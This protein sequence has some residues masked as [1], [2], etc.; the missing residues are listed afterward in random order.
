MAEGVEAAGALRRRRLAVALEHGRG[1]HG[2][3]ALE[4]RDAAAADEVVAVDGAAAGAHLGREARPVA[5]QVLDDAGAS[6]AEHRLTGAQAGDVREHVLGLQ[7]QLLRRQLA[8]EAGEVDGYAGQ[9]DAGQAGEL[10]GDRPGGVRKDAFA[11]VAEVDGEQ[12][13]HGGAGD[14]LSEHAG[15]ARVAEQHAVGHLGRRLE[16]VPLGRPDERE[17]P[18]RLSGEPDQR[19]QA[20]VGEAGAAGLE[21]H[22]P[23]RRLAVHALGDAGERQAAGVQVRGETPRGAGDGAEID[24]EPGERQTFSTSSGRERSWPLRLRAAGGA[25]VCRSHG[26]RAGAGGDRLR[27]EDAGPPAGRSRGAG[28]TARVRGGGY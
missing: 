9:L 14:V 2:V 5:V 16:F 25:G 28:A 23:D 11:A 18:Q 8:G 6:E 4:P 7:E 1:E 12:Q 13:L 17:R 19:G 26:V 3:G 15:G 21:Q 20:A 27:A 22:P 24:G 10:G